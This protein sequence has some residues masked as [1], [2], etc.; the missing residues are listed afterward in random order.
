[1]D[2]LEEVNALL[3]NALVAVSPDVAVRVKQ[4]IGRQYYVVV[5]E[6][7]FGM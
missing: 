6:V 3:E 7:R 5:V 1:M 4:I 2:F